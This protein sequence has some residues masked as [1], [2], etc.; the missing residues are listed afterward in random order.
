MYAWVMIYGGQ[1]V[2]HVAHASLID[3]KEQRSCYSSAP[4][5]SKELPE[6]GCRSTTDCLRGSNYDYYIHK[7]ST[8]PT[9]SDL[10]GGA[11]GIDD[12]TA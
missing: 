9:L 4:V 7:M 8:Q 6:R 10:L 11:A 12:P 5:P 1:A 2:A 3:P